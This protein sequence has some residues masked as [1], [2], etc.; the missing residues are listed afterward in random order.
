MAFYDEYANHK[1]SK[2]GRIL[3]E[4]F[5]SMINSIVDSYV[6]PEGSIVEI[7]VGQGG[8]AYTLHEKYTYSGYELNPSLV[9]YHCNNGLH[10]CNKAVPPLAEGD[11]TVDA[12][13]A[14]H[15]VEHMIHMNAA[16]ELLKEI[17]ITS[18][19]YQP[20]MNSNLWLLV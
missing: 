13:L 18:R 1:I 19:P 15:V 2:P 5:Y 20:V 4:Y 17:I 14:I 3:N 12:V 10:V 8:L 6:A 9:E 11:A 7:G 16:I